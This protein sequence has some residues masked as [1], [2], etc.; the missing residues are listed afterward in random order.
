MTI[1]GGLGG[2]GGCGGDGGSGGCSGD[3]GSGGCGGD[4]VLLTHARSPCRMPSAGQPGGFTSSLE[5][6]IYVNFL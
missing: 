6:K 2:S 4:G 3:G 5:T 1:D